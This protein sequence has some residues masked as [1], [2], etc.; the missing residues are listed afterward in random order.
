MTARTWRS[1]SKENRRGAWDWQN[2]EKFEQR[3]S[4]RVQDRQ[5][6]EKFEQRESKRGTGQDQHGEV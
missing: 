1:L 5:K 6:M 3:E 2:M 4:K